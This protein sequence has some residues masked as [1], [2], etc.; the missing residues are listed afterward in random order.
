MLQVSV[1]SKPSKQ[2]LPTAQDDRRDR[3]GP[4]IP[5]D[6]ASVSRRTGSSDGNSG[7]RRRLPR[8]QIWC[9][10]L[11]T[12]LLCGPIVASPEGNELAERAGVSVAYVERL[13]ERG[14]IKPS[15]TDRRSFSD[16]DV[17]RIRFIRSLED[18][19]VPLDGIGRAVAKADLSLAFL[20]S[21]AWGRFA[22]LVADT[23]R[24]V[25]ARTGVDIEVLRSIR[26]AIGFARPEA[27]D[28]L[29]ED[30]LVVVEWLKAS[31][32]AG[33]DV[34]ATERLLRVWGE[35]A[36]QIAEAGSQWFHTQ[37]EVPLLEAGMTE[38]E[39]V[40]AGARA[41]AGFGP[42]VDKA[43]GAIF[44]AQSEHTWTESKIEAV[45]AA[46]EHIGVRRSDARQ[47]AICFVD[48]TG[49]T[50]LTEERGDVAAAE[51][52]T[53]LG[54]LVRRNADHRGGR[55]VKW[56]GDGVMLYFADP[57]GALRFAIDTVERIPAAGLPPAH[58]G[59]DS[60][61]VVVQDGDYFGRT[62]NIAARIAA[63]AHAGE[64]LV[65]DEV[66]RAATEAGVMF[67][68][69]GVVRLKGLSAPLRL[70][71]ARRS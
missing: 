36:R 71:R 37:I 25:S 65:S 48:M 8:R 47:P 27:D 5:E 52:A 23:Y 39:V 12:P 9:V 59:I 3:F 67:T 40:A 19:G 29:R 44:H 1:S 15:S 32:D 50:R 55:P 10:S 70:Y 42:L 13:I 43:V 61:P 45:E 28:H 31:L 33:A 54:S 17:R 69:I 34:A 63:H 51:I 2:T 35:A 21:A 49:Y 4:R 60:G 56:L 14:L 58:V 6:S 66:A 11:A 20:D 53:T 46:L 18:G 62:V 24:G 41:A 26:E 7:Q 30:E 38:G 64:T 22:G 16:G 68:D 57:S